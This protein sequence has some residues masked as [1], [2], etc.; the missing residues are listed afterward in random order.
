[1]KIQIENY[2]F[3]ASAGTISFDDFASIRLDS[4]LPIINVKDD[5]A[6]YNPIS[7]I[8]GGT[9]SGNVLT[10]E[11]N[12]LHMDNDDALL[13]FYEDQE[14]PASR[15]KQSDTITELKVAKVVDT[16]N[17]TDT[18]LVG[19]DAFDGAWIDT[20]G[21]T[22][23]LIQILTDKDSAIDGLEIQT[24]YS[25]DPTRIHEHKFTVDANST[26]GGSHFE[27]ALPG[28]QYRI[29]YTNGSVTQ[30]IFSLSAVLSKYGSGI[31]MHPANFAFD[32]NHPVQ[33]GRNIIAGKTPDGTYEN[34]ELSANNALLV[35][36][37]PHELPEISYHMTKVDGVTDTIAVQS[38]KGD[39]II[40]VGDGTKWAVNDKIKILDGDNTEYD[41]I[42]IISI[43]GDDLT[44]DRALDD[45]HLVGE[46]V[47]GVDE[48]MAVDGSVT[49]QTFEYTPRAGQNIHIHTLH[50]TMRSS[51]E[52]AL[53]R[54]GGIAALT[55]G[56]H[57]RIKNIT[58]RDNTYW[59]PFRSN[60]A[61]RL[62]GF[63]YIKEA[64]VLTDWYIH[65]SISLVDDTNSIIFLDGDDGQ[66]FEAIV[67]DDLTGL[68]NMEIKLGLHEEPQ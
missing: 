65:M 22:T 47:V 57:L 9:V 44:L 29:V 42:K 31:H 52:P 53:G 45:I 6:I 68:D 49:N 58:G 62:S 38:A 64:K 56:V 5:K 13:I 27:S 25:S 66:S 4:V 18:V 11:K 50:I 10:L 61:F 19:D 41:I 46:D 54:F 24:R 17:S 51:T 15:S 48:N 55:N 3:N 35:H 7:T 28:D 23:V 34:A 8:L 60:N 59:I 40:T 21:A 43:S 37:D 39:K 63:D 33:S 36:N 32:D 14:L 30:T 67:Q 12:T 20:L 1:M 16:E 26:S 2:T